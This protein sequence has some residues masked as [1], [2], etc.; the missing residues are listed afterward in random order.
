MMHPESPASLTHLGFLS[1]LSEPIGTLGGYL[2]TN[3]WGRPFEFRLTSAVQPTRVQ[4]ILYGP[5]LGSYVCG[6]LIAKTLIDKSS[7]PVQWLL[8]DHPAVL[9]IRGRCAM[10]ISLWKAGEACTDNLLVAGPNLYCD[11][12]FPGDVPA[13]ESFLARLGNLDLSE[14]FQRIRDAIHEARK[15]GV[16]KAA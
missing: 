12:Q 16:S 2:I 4:H 6:E 1:I 9:S 10:P 15:M 7:T 3:S 13:V 5:A 14:P 8:T 11:D